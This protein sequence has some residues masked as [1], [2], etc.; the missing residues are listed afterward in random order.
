MTRRERQG[1]RAPGKARWLVGMLLWGWACVLGACRDPAA[2]SGTALYVTAE[3]DSTL[4]LTQLEASAT[5]PGDVPVGPS[6][7]PELPDRFLRSGETFR[8]L[9]PSAPDEALAELRVQG[10]RDGVAVAS[11]AGTVQVRAGYEVDVTVRLLPPSAEP[12]D[13]GHPSDDGGTPDGGGGGGPP[14]AGFCANCRDGC[15]MGGLCTDSTFNT[16]GTGGITCRQCDA[17]TT[18]VCLPQGVCGCGDG[19]ACTWPQVDQCA[20]GQCKCGGGGACGAGQVCVGGQCRC[21]PES[22][23]GCCSGNVCMPGSARDF[24]GKAGQACRDCRKR[25]NADGTCD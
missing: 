5:V 7:L 19:P 8:V 1:R 9:L 16:C 25:C 6:R 3:F 20:G 18:N 23:N 17:V 12:P 11:G 15:C 10:L 2:A 24:C 22:C 14:D 4:L 13:G 21:T